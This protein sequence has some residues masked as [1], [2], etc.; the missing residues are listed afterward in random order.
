MPPLFLIYLLCSFCL[1][2]SLPC[3]STAHGFIG[4]VVSLNMWFEQHMLDCFSVLQNAH[5]FFSSEHIKQSSA[6]LPPTPLFLLPVHTLLPVA[7]NVI[8]YKYMQFL[9]GLSCFGICIRITTFTM[10]WRRKFLAWLLLD[11]SPAANS[12][13][14]D[15]TWPVY[16]GALIH[17]G[18]YS[19]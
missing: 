3:Q 15:P 11:L 10:T 12:V 5:A 16:Q 17:V 1:N 13:T 18:C 14:F 6:L 4:D 2:H 19:W 7:A 8:I 9:L